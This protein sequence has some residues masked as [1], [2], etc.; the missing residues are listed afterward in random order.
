MA[1]GGH[2]ALTEQSCPVH[3]GRIRVSPLPVLPHCYAYHNPSPNSPRFLINLKDMGQTCN[4]FGGECIPCGFWK[5]LR[6]YN[7]SQ[8]WALWLPGDQV[9]SGPEAT[10]RKGV[11]GVQ[12][13]GPWRYIS[14]SSISQ[15]QGLGEF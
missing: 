5:A 4:T 15:L 3:S 6:T 11:P 2:E 13:E 9:K 10:H 7:G 8:W 12:W 1:R 14:T